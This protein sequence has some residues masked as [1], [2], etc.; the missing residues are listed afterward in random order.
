MVRIP[1]SHNV[2]RITNSDVKLIQ[3]W[4][5]YR[6][7]I[8]YLL[9]DFRRYLIDQRMGE[10]KAQH[11]RQQNYQCFRFTTNSIQWIEQL[12]LIPIP[13]YRKLAIW[14][15]IAPY[16]L[17][18]C[19]LSLDEADSIMS[20]WLDKCSQLRRLNFNPSYRIK[21]VLNSSKGFLPVSCEKLKTE[22]EGLY[23]LL[24][25]KGVLT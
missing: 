5:G 2:K 25:D 20:E 19:R 7:P 24:Q 8:N 21:S 4:N 14:R 1:G 17:N 13:D 18:V 6:L 10:V 23:N 11:K 9:R 12:L 15:I 22:N 3:V 16:L